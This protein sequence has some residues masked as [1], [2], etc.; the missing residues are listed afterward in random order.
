MA[1]PGP[2]EFRF[3]QWMVKTVCVEK[4]D[5]ET[6]AL[7]FS[8]PQPPFRE[9]TADQLWRH[10]FSQTPDDGR[11]S[12]SQEEIGQWYANQGF[13]WRPKTW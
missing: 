7:D 1:K 12:V 2:N 8:Q 10:Y 4:R 3:S 11:K 9:A 13:F 5:P 6:G